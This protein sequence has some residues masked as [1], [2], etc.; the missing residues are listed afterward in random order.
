MHLDQG[1]GVHLSAAKSRPD[2]WGHRERV[3]ESR[4]WGGLIIGPLAIAVRGGEKRDFGPID[5]SEQRRRE[6]G[7]GK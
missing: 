4:T 5:V 7:N 1:R 6:G 2:R 3:D